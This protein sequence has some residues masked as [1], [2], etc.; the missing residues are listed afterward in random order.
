MK[1]ISWNI[2]NFKTNNL[3]LQ[4]FNLQ[5]DMILLQ[6]T[7]LFNYESNLIENSFR[8]Y[9]CVS[10]SSMPNYRNGVKGRPYGGTAILVKKQFENS[11][12]EVDSSDP[13][14]LSILLDTKKGKLLVINV[15][16]PCNS[17]QNDD[18]ITEYFGAIESRISKSDCMVIV[19]GD[20][21]V[22][23]L[24]KK[25]SELQQL[26]CDL[27]L[28]VADVNQLDENSF[29][30]V[31]KS[32]GAVSWIDHCVASKNLINSVEI[33]HLCSPSD[34]VP[35]VVDA[36]VECIQTAN[37]HVAPRSLPKI[38]WKSVSLTRK[39]EYCYRVQ[40]QVRRFNWNICDHKNCSSMNHQAIITE[41]IKLLFSILQVSSSFLLPSNKKRPYKQE[42]GWNDHVSVHYAE[43]RCAFQKWSDGG[44]L[45]ANLYSNMCLKRNRFKSALRLCRKQ[46]KMR[47]HEELVT[48]YEGKDFFKF[49]DHVKKHDHVENPTSDMIDGVKGSADISEY[50]A[51]FYSEFFNKPQSKMYENDVNEYISNT[52]QNDNIIILE[53]DVNNVI[54][55]LKSG[56]AKGAE[57]LQSEH[58]LFACD[59]IVPVITK[60]IHSMISHGFVPN[61]VMTVLISPILKKKNAD[62]SKSSN[63][64][65]IA[66]ATTFSKIFELLLLA[67]CENMLRTTDNQFGFKKKVGT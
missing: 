32:N 51:G 60:L 18:L 28:E 57:G 35:L 15:Y 64:R 13:R 26:C 19:M 41:K 66:I 37:N 10:A 5:Y 58:Y 2:Q 45:C 40:Q 23:P 44:K 11:I 3:W 20:F 38:K 56:K 16:L 43:Y 30:F 59:A 62:I 50:W 22:S 42:H 47:L 33:P 49:W 65:P 24:S 54:H 14:L 12:K 8:D 39:L 67:K 61:E 4:Q 6:E 27:E 17:F 46:K 48:S 9:K 1:I 63:Y 52:G 36:D 31:S 25:F 7:W 53:A 21:N 29:T 55:A 34:H